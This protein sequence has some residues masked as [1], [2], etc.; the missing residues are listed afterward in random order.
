MPTQT[1]IMDAIY[2]WPT[3]AEITER[4]GSTINV[5]SSQLRELEK[6]GLVK[7]HP[8]MTPLCYRLTRPYNSTADAHA[9]FESYYAY[10]RGELDEG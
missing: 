3:A 10:K 2:G 1:Q 6:K 4:V 7:T 9:C 5:V 8:F